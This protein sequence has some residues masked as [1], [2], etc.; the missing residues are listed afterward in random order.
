MNRAP[1]VPPEVDLQDFAFMPLDVRRLRDSDLTADESPEACWAAVLLWSASW[2]Q[3]PAGSIPN[4]EQWIAKHAGYSAR[5]RIDPAWKTVRDGAMRSWILCSDD[6]WYHPVVA[7]KAIEAWRSKREHAYRKLCDRMRKENKAHEQAGE[8]TVRIPS[9]DQWNSAGNPTETPRIPQEPIKTSADAAADS[10]GIPLE[11][12]LKGTEGI[13]TGTGTGILKPRQP[14]GCSSLATVPMPP[15]DPI[16]DPPE[17]PLRPSLALVPPSPEPLP[18]PHERIVAAYHRLLPSLPRVREWTPLRRSHLAAR[19]KAKRDRQ[20]VEWWEQIFA[21]AG[22]SP[23]LLG[24]SPA[25]DGRK[26][27][28]LTLDWLVKSEDNLV[29]L[30]EGRYEE[31]A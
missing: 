1:L 20:S 4:N 19:W 27:F 18:C 17:P 12:P 22:K 28:V 6:R 2:H 5:G 3:I 26:P 16:P 7:E 24:Q 21:Y 25:R 30:I 11:I 9:F 29:K 8:K 23:F 15:P 31:Q 14:G 10:A 13:G